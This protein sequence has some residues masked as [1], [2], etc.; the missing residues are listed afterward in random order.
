MMMNKSS[1]AIAISTPT[2]VPCHKGARPFLVSSAVFLCCLAGAFRRFFRGGCAAFPCRFCIFPLNF[3]LLHETGKGVCCEAAVIVQGF[4]I[5]KVGVCLCRRFFRLRRLAV[6]FQL[7]A[8]VALFDLSDTVF[9]MRSAASSDLCA[10][11]TPELSFS[12]ECILLWTK[13]PASCAGR[14]KGIALAL[15]ARRRFLLVK[16]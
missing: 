10:P 13:I 2:G 12:T 14:D 11:S 6:R 8:A 9:P 1:A 4:V 7:V 5:V 3:L 16:L 15:E